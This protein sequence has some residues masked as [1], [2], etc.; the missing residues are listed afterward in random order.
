MSAD[1]RH[2]RQAFRF[3]TVVDGQ[4]CE[5]DYRLEGERMVITHTGVPAAVG[6]RGIGGRLVEAA[7]AAAREAGWRVEPRCSYAAEW[8]R[9]H[10][11]VHGLLVPGFISG[12]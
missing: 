12:S 8:A 11:E 3:E 2:D 7:F 5:L 10:P 1:I 9:R 4:S 6:G